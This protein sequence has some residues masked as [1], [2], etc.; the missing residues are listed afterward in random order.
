MPEIW[1]PWKSENFPSPGP[2]CSNMQAALRNQTPLC[3]FC[4]CS[5]KNEKVC[6]LWH[7]FTR[8]PSLRLGA[9]MKCKYMGSSSS[10]IS[11]EPDMAR[12]QHTSSLSIVFG[13]KRKPCRDVR[14]KER[15]PSH[16]FQHYQLH[17]SLFLPYQMTSFAIM[18]HTFPPVQE[19]SV[20]A[21]LYCFF[22]LPSVSRQTHWSKIPPMSEATDF[23]K[24][25][26]VRQSDNESKGVNSDINT[27]SSSVSHFL[28][29]EY[30]FS[31][32]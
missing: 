30:R 21:V 16:S 24:R 15:N 23:N 3:V 1:L 29:P 28:K 13:W 18:A 31:G 26:K 17:S 4:I 19:C 32:V 6:F 10:A 12:D 11:W 2:A 8:K 27:H 25:Q 22:F 5:V 20:L 9:G 14:S 7:N